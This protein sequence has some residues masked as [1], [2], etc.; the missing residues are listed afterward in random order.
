MTTM[1]MGRLNDETVKSMVDVTLGG[2]KP[3]VDEEAKKEA[4][5]VVEPKLSL[6][7]TVRVC[8]TVD[9]DHVDDYDGAAGVQRARKEGVGDLQRRRVH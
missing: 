4:G 6:L 7:T 3:K 9:H 2:V 8:P 1:T 5:V